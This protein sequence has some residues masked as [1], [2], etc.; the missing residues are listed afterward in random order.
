MLTPGGI[1]FFLGA[2]KELTSTAVEQVLPSRDEQLKT[3]RLDDGRKFTIIK[4]FW[5]AAALEGKCTRAGLDVEI[6]ETVYY[7]NSP[8]RE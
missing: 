3:R 8:W 5:S 1:L 6:H 4:N 2:G 7:F